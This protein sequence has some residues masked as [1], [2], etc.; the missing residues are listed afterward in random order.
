M[1]KRPAFREI[2][3]LWRP[4]PCSFKQAE[5]CPEPATWFSV[6]DAEIFLCEQHKQQMERQARET[7]AL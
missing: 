2:P 1:R 3:K 6:I 7:E 5:Q 4:I